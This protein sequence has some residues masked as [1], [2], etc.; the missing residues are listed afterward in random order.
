MKGSI[1]VLELAQLQGI[2]RPEGKSILEDKEGVVKEM[3][4]VY[5]L[6]KKKKR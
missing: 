5:Y 3:K 6:K 2:T 1:K 4:S